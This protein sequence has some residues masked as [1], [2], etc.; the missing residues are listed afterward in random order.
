MC[1][2]CGYYGLFDSW[3]HADV[4]EDFHGE[5]CPHVELVEIP[6]EWTVLRDKVVETARI[7]VAETINGVSRKTLYDFFFAVKTLEEYEHQHKE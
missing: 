4:A 1:T 7:Y 5:H 3:D 6:T 2:D